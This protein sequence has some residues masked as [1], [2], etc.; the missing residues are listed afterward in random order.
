MFE[1]G[2]LKIKNSFYFSN[3]FQKNLLNQ[4]VKIITPNKQL[5]IL[6]QDKKIRKNNRMKTFNKLFINKRN[7]NSINFISTLM[8]Y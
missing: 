5:T 2:K 4:N 6:F 8:F 7:I 1:K 3:F